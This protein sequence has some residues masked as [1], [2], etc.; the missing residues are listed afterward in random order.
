MALGKTQKTTMRN[1]SIL[2]CGSS[3]TRSLYD[4]LMTFGLRPI[5]L[6]SDAPVEMVASLDPL[7]IFISGSPEYVNAPKA[8]RIDT[9][10]YRLDTP[11]MGI[12]YGMQLIA[13]DFGGKVKRMKEREK[14]LVHMDLTD[15][16]SVLF[17]DFTE[18]GVPV[19]M[20]HVCKVTAVPEN[21]SVTGYTADTE[22]AAM[23][24]E[25]LGIYAVQFHPEHVGKD[26]SS[27][28]GTSIIWNFLNGI[29]GY[30][31]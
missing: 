6:P 16:P 19:W 2:Y 31:G 22:A 3:F 14:K 20:A 30:S 1:V 29:C 8:P 28:A 15:Q 21:F 9:E 27:Q 5:L 24:N 7:G 18:D 12:C 4:T 23:E 26:A 17:R 25:E 10:V 13:K 11:I